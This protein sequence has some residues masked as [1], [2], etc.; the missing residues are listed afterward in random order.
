MDFKFIFAGKSKDEFIKLGIEK[1][2]KILKKYGKVEISE[3]KDNEGKVINQLRNN[4]FVILLDLKGKEY[5]TEEMAEKFQKWKDSG[6]FRFDIVSGGA[7]GV[8]DNILRKSD[9]LWKLSK[10]TFNHQIVRLIIL[11]QVYRILS[12]LNNESYHH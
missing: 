3:P 10:L 7:Y 5:S 8:S 4:S 11:E 6:I 1:Y 12:I 2:K 9:F